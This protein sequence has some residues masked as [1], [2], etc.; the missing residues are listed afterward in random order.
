[1]EQ[2]QID[3]CVIVAL[4]GLWYMFS[5]IKEKRR[6]KRVAVVEDSD[7]DFM[8][9]KMF[10][11]LDNVII[12]RYRTADNLAIEFAKNRP[13]VVIVDYYLDGRIRGDDLIRFC[14]RIGIKSRLATGSEGPIGDLPEHRIFRK[15]PDQEYFDKLRNYIELSINGAVA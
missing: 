13:D 12:D 9:F 8:L 4:G 14:D 1:M 2:W 10:I 5:W 3:V 6:P 7:D 11:H 15:S